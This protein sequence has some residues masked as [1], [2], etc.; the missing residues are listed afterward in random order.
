MTEHAPAPGRQD[1]LGIAGVVPP[2]VT[3][4]DESG[5]VDPEATV[6]HAEFVTE[7]GAAAVFPLGTNGEFALLSDD[8]R[9]RVVEAVAESVDVPVIAGVGAPATRTTVAHARHAESVGADGVVAVT[10]YYYPVDEDGAVEH[11]R[12]LAG[13]VDVPVYVYHIPSKTGNELSLSAVERIAAID[14]VAGLKDSSK[15]VPWLAEAID[16]R[17]ELTYM[18][19]SDSLLHAGL[20][21]GCAGLVSAVANVFPELVVD[22]YAAYDA[23]EE[24]RAGELQSEVFGVRNALK[25]GPYMAGVKTALQLRDLPFDV[26]GLREPLRTMGD[27][28]R[29]ELEADLRD[30]GLL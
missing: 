3:A 1:P 8:E 23:G 14:G 17:P 18:A 6:A 28:E 15:D 27:G 9:R 25:R 7:A 4:F 11:Y 16:R 20:D 12:R 26:G 24:E 13:A 29:R 2:T 5:A 21:L 10:P 30:L 19:G 22:L